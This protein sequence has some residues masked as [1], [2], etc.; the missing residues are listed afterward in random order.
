MKTSTLRYPHSGWTRWVVV[1]AYAHPLKIVFYEY[2]NHQASRWFYSQDVLAASPMSYRKYQPFNVRV[3]CNGMDENIFLAPI[4]KT[5][6]RNHRIKPWLRKYMHEEL[7]VAACQSGEGSSIL[8][9][10]VVTVMSQLENEP[11]SF[12]LDAFWLLE[13]AFS[14]HCA[15]STMLFTEKA[16]PAFYGFPEIITQKKNLT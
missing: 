13:R 3:Q 7:Y 8:E 4:E 5:S 15:K 1:T 14:H 6:F 9:G 2:P 10:S 12:Y 11:S 16:T